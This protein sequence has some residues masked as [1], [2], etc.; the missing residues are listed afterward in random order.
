MGT[1]LL[2]IAEARKRLKVS[3]ATL[4]NLIR[5]GK[6]ALVKV[7]KRSLVPEGA[8]ERLIE[9]S[10][11]P[12][13]RGGD[14]RRRREQWFDAL[15]RAGVVWAGSRQALVAPAMSPFRPVKA[16]GIPAS[17]LVLAERGQL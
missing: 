4:Y 9:E 2:T 17:D 10:R 13:H 11:P 8:L 6:L 16:Q 5:A 1:R 3:R 15:L 14:E 7:G 12:R